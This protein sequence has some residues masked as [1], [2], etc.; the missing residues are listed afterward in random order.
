MA[1][2]PLKLDVTLEVEATDSLVAIDFLCD[3]I[4][5]SK[6]RLKAT[7]NSGAVWLVRKGQARKRLRRAMTDL[8]PGDILEIFYDEALLSQKVVKP[9]LVEDNELYSIW[10]KPQGLLSQGTDWGD[11]HSLLRQVELHFAGRRRVFLI[12]RLDREA[13][14]LLLLAHHPRSAAAFSELFAG[15][16]VEKTYR[17]EVLGKV[18]EPGS[19]GVIDQPLDS[20][21]AITNWQML[22]FVEHTNHSVLEVTLKTG[23]LHQIRRH[24]DFI[25]HPVIGDPRYG[26]GNKNIEGLK[27]VAIGLAFTCPLT[28]TSKSYSAADFV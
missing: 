10:Y 15:D 1:N 25:G 23:R 7:M 16:Q 17:I 6:S 8:K 11:Q 14:G 24:F 5:L 27:L 2:V 18:A 21:V 19:Q 26:R 28:K 9:T 20:K 3:N 12:H 13:R 22:H 4:N